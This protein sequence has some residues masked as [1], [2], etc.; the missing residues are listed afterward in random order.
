MMTLNLEE[1]RA[2]LPTLRKSYC[3]ACL[4]ASIFCL[5]FHKHRSGIIANS[6]SQNEKRYQ[7]LWNAIN[8]TGFED[9]WEDRIEAV[10]YGASCIAVLIALKIT[11]CNTVKRSARKSGIDFWIGESSL[12]EKSAIHMQ[13]MARLEISGILNGNESKVKQRIKQKRIQVKQS[14]DTGL[15]VFIIVVEF[16]QPTI[17]VAEQ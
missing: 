9:T 4:E 15:P 7:L 10:E 12:I 17:S 2:G 11:K 8:D 3:C 16:S 6:L 1:L 13:K 5:Q 14:D